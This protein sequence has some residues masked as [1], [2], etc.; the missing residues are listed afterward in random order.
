MVF[1][2]HKV[3]DTDEKHIEFEAL[4]GAE[5]LGKCV[6]S[7]ADSVAEITEISLSEDDHNTVEGL[8]RAAF[9]YAANRNYYIGICNAEGVDKYLEKMNFSKTDKGFTNDIPSILMGSC[10]NCAK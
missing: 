7:L 2:K 5:I 1:F 3:I 8:V 4:C 6:L 10:K 9:N